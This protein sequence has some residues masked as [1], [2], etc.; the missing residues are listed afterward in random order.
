MKL[1]MTWFPETFI[2]FCN[3]LENK[4]TLG[5]AI[6]IER[7]S[8]LLFSV[9][10]TDNK[11]LRG[12]NVTSSG[13]TTTTVIGVGA[14]LARQSQVVLNGT[15]IPVRVS[16]N[17]NTAFVLSYAYLFVIG[18]VIFE[19]NQGSKGGAIGLYEESAV[20]LYDRTYLLFK[21]NKANVGGALYVF[22][23]GPTIPIWNS[24]D[25]FLYKCF[26]QFLETTQETFKGNVIFV[27][28]DAARKD[29][30]AIFSNL[31]QTC[32]KSSSE[33]SSRI[34][35]S[36]PNFNFTGNFTSF[37]TTVPVKIITKEEEWNNLQ[38]RIKFSANISL[39][40]ERGQSVEAPIEITF[41][42]EGIVYIKNS[43]MIVSKNRVDLKIFGVQNTPFN[44][45]IKTP[46]GRALPKKIINK[47]LKICGFGFSF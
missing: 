40:D 25:L 23:T 44:I 26:F 46:S 34:L 30:D 24:P 31:L 7:T 20:T 19:D 41:E 14:L 12:T 22:V 1:S 11:T 42:P 35:T 37:I 36:W 29:G 32:K 33:D 5:S 16:R 21:S 28:N 15:E 38:P 18:T 9:N 3:F 45:T 13:P 8:L 27:D 10:I 39:I 43:R 4:A 17:F 47:T 6:F 2:E